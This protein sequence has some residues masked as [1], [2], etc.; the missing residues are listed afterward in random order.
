VEQLALIQ[1]SKASLQS[2]ERRCT[3]DTDGGTG[4]E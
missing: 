2:G 1:L 4:R 3:R